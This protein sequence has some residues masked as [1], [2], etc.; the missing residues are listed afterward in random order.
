[1]ELTASYDTA[2][3]EL[4]RRLRITRTKLTMLR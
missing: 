4:E 1:M 2:R 3:A